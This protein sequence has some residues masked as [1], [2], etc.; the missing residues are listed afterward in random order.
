[1][2]FQSEK[3]RRYMHAN[4]PDIANRWEA[5]Y[6][7]GG[8]AEL[9]AQLNDLPEYYIPKNQGGRIGYSQGSGNYLQYVQA[10]NALNLQPMPLEIFNSLRPILSVQEMVDMG[11]PGKAEGGLIPS[12]QAGIY[13]LAEGG[14]PDIGFSKVKPSNDGSRPGYFTAEYGGGGGKASDTG[15]SSGGGGGEAGHLSHNVPVSLGG[16]KAD[17]TPDRGNGRHHPGVDTGTEEEAYVV[18]DGKKVHQP[19]WGTKDD[20]REQI[21]YTGGE[22]LEEI[23]EIDLENARRKLKYDPNLTK[24]E[25]EG[26][27]VGLG[28]R[29][30]KQKTSIL[31]FLGKGILTLATAGAGAGL[32]GKDIMKI[33]GLY[34]KYNQG[35]KIFN[36]LKKGELDLGFTKVNLNKVT[37]KLKSSNQKLMESLPKGHPERIALEAKMKVKTP[38][39]HEGEGATTSIK[40]E[41][42]ETVND[43]HAEQVQ[44]KK[45]RDMELASYQIMMQQQEDRSKQMAYWNQLMA[46]YMAAGGGRVPGYNTGGLSNLFRLKNV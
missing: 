13:G 40:I 43:A 44:L 19:K 2:P 38:P 39:K 27:E 31:G 9:N 18:V 45:Y 34:N 12:H 8:I 7:L 29:Q 36:T 42:I 33:A 22:D 16:T 17:P 24:Q 46:P 10:M 11:S 23:L 3:Q 4:L 41:D 14:V 1:M 32:F 35:K 25:R 21:E 28:L 5:K 26:L 15:S 20:P 37:N 6:G 30:P